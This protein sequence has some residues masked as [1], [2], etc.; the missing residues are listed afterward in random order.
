[1]TKKIIVAALERSRQTYVSELKE[2]YPN[3]EIDEVQSGKDLVDRV[4]SGGYCLVISDGHMAEK[5][6]GLKA[7]SQIREV[8][9]DVPFYMCCGR[10]AG[11]EALS[12]GANGFGSP[13]TFDRAAIS[14][15]LSE[16]LR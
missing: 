3:I 10:I 1:M 11:H 7:L 5:N 14:L 16:Y 4:L 15:Y 6:E 2:I 9:I 12:L 8:G 13:L